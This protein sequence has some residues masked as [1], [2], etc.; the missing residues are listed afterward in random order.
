MQV[1]SCKLATAEEDGGGGVR[2]LRFSRLAF[3]WR[4][5]S[6]PSNKILYRRIVASHDMTMPAAPLKSGRR[7]RPSISTAVPAGNTATFP[8]DMGGGAVGAN[9]KASASINGGSHRGFGCELWMIKL[10]ASEQP[11][12]LGDKQG[13][14]VEHISSCSSSPKEL[15]RLPRVLGLSFGVIGT[16]NVSAMFRKSEGNDRA[17]GVDDDLCS[18]ASTQASINVFFTRVLN[19]CARFLKRC[20]RRSAP[21]P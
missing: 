12:Y 8:G 2:N 13:D 14:G 11:K 17:K 1:S 4:W 19:P 7:R 9:P 5:T 16:T 15:L 20:S 3:T 18:A 10:G 6:P 21:N